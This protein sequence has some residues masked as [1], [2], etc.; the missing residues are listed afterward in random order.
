MWKPTEKLFLTRKRKKKGETESSLARIW[1]L[2][3]VKVNERA[4]HI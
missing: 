3:V 1:M 4:Q 2:Q